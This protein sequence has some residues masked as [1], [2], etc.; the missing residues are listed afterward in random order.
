MATCRSF[1]ML[2]PRN[3]ARNPVMFL[4]EVG[5]VLTTLVTI[6]SIVDRARRPA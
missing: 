3:M 2:D 5:W 4:V 1:V 6:E